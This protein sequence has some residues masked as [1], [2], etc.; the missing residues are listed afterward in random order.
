MSDDNRRILVVDDNESIQADIRKILVPPPV[1]QDLHALAA[2]LF[3]AEVKPPPRARQLEGRELELE[4]ARQGGEAVEMIGEA[5]ESCTPYAMAF[6]DLRMPP[7]MDGIETIEKAWQVDPELQVVL[8]TAYSD[9]SWEEIYER[10]GPSDSFFV[11]KKP[12]EIVEIQQIAHT[13]VERWNQRRSMQRI[14]EELSDKVKEL[15]EA[16]EHVKQL[17]EF[18]PICSYCK[19]IKDDE[20]VWQQLE[21]YFYDHADVKFSHGICE[22]CLVEHFPEYVPE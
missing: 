11:L 4:F 15:Q 10:L 5:L 12:F 19:R 1:K 22:D 17:Q 21:Q 18:L 2:D 7:G 20:S 16:L 8:C 3:E 13:L 9:Y 14:R 6:V